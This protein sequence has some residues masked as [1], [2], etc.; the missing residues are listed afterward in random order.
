MK[1]IVSLFLLAVLVFSLVVCFTACGGSSSSSSSYSYEP[2]VLTESEKEDVAEDKALEYISQFPLFRGD[3]TK[4]KIGS[5]T[6]KSDG[7]VIIKG[8]LLTYDSYGNY[9]DRYTF[10]C[11]VSVS[12]YGLAEV[13]DFDYDLQ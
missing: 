12:D 6:S 5:R 2:E 7:T 13:E 3:G 9:S 1:K 4:Y 8:Q 10:T 11:T